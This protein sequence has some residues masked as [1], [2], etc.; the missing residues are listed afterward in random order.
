MD[1]PVMNDDTALMLAMLDLML[2]RNASEGEFPRLIRD[3]LE[4]ALN[5]DGEPAAQ[6]VECL[7]D[8]SR[9]QIH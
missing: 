1:E 8:W 4:D 3:A 9:T 6:L 2:S 7:Y 5:G